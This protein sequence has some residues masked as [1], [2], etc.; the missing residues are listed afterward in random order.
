MS[1]LWYPFELTNAVYFLFHDGLSYIHAVD[2]CNDQSL[3]SLNLNLAWSWLL[4]KADK[5]LK[6]TF[7][8]FVS[9]N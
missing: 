9:L 2:I 7:L 4:D 1:Q 3:K 6:F 8:S 5:L